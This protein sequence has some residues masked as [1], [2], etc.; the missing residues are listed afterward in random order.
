[1]AEGLPVVDAALT[2]ESAGAA[3]TSLSQKRKRGRSHGWSRKKPDHQK[4]R[5]KS[6]GAD[7][8]EVFVGDEENVPVVQPL[9]PGRTSVKLTVTLPPLA[10]L[11]QAPMDTATEVVPTV[12]ETFCYCN[13]VA[14]GE[15]RSMIWCFHH[16]DK[17][18]IS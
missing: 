18:P 5:V 7:R 8:A 17:S 13:G 6:E 16:S 15:V 1:M 9:E 14:Y 12:E 4:D 11:Q 2:T 3:A 10:S